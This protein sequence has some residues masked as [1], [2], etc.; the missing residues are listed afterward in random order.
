MSH[1]DSYAAFKNY[2]TPSLGSKHIR[3]F[4]REVWTPA[5]FT[6]DHAVLE[7]GC[8]TGLFLA[9]LA[10]K[11]VTD[12]VGIDRDPELAGVVPE[13]VRGRFHVADAQIF[14]KDARARG[15]IYDRIALFD[16]LEHFDA[17]EGRGL[18]LGIRE[19]LAPDGRIVVK[20]PN[21]ASPWG[22]QFQYGDLTH[23]TAY[24]PESLAQQAI[25]AGFICQATWPHRL[26]SPARQTW[27]G[28][29]HAILDKLLASPPTIWQGNFYGLLAPAAARP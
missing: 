9:Y 10:A 19:I 25:A 3:R 11:G 27:E 4:D 15:E 16:V 17:D 6:A 18:L 21:A 13:A 8:G 7:I 29:L 20:V 22:Q 5:A 26:G 1:Y 24:T 12:V 28:M 2:S 23:R 14:V